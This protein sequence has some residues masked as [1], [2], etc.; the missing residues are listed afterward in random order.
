MRII[1]IFLISSFLFSCGKPKT[2]LICGDHA[3]VNKA[4]AEQYFE[5]NLSLEVKIL[6]NKKRTIIFF[7]VMCLR[8]CSNSDLFLM[9][10]IEFNNRLNHI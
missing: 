7:I 9:P 5:E 8:S 2:V 10:S 1:L 4:E 3:C 6:R